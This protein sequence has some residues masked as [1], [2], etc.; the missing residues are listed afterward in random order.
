MKWKKMSKSE[1]KEIRTE[2][3]KKDYAVYCKVGVARNG[4]P[5]R[6]FSEWAKWVWTRRQQD[7]K[8]VFNGM[9]FGDYVS[10]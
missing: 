4:A 10:V 5:E 9:T 2:N 3:L 6:T 8:S 1:L 7:K